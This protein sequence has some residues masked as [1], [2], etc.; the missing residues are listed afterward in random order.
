[1]ITRRSFVGV[2]SAVPFARLF[3]LSTKS[4]GRASLSASPGAGSEDFTKYVKIRIGTGGHGHTY[5]GA[6]VPFGMVQLSPD[7]Y[8]DGWDWCSGYHYSDSSI[9][10]FSHTHLSGTGASDMLDFLL[11]PGTGLTKLVPGARQNPGEGYRSR[12]SHEE[13]IAEPGY[14]SV[15]LRDY[16]IRAELSATERAGIHRYTF[17]KSDSSHFIL[18][19]V[20]AYGN[21][22]VVWAYLKVV[23]NDTIVGGRSMKGWAPDREIYFA[24]QFSK[25]FKKV[26]IV[27]DD[28]RMD[29]STRE[30][31]G[32]ALK[33]LLHFDTGDKEAI[34][35]KTGISGVSDEGARKNVAAEIPGWDFDKVRRSAHGAWNQQLSRIKIETTNQRHKRIFY[36]GLYHMLVAPT[37]FDDVDGQYRGM[38]NKIHQL[39][40][41]AHNYS[42]FSLWDTFRAAHPMYTLFQTDRV[43]DFVNCLIRMAQESP[44]G[45]PVW[46]LQG[47][48]TGT[49]TGYHSSSVYAEALVKGFKG[50]NFNQLYS[51]LRRRAMDDDYRGLGY[52]RKLGYI[53]CDKEEESVSKTMEY[54]Y[55]DW[56]VAHVAKALGHEDD[57]KLLIERSRNYKNLFDTGTTF[58]RPKLENG[59][60]AEP[61]DPTE[62]GHSKQWRD[63]TESDPWETTFSIQ[64]DPAGYIKLFGSREAFIEKLDTLFTTSSKLPADAPPDIAGMVG[65]YA[66]GNEVPSHGL[67]LSLRRRAGEDAGAGAKLAGDGVRRSAGRL[68]G[69]RRLRTDVGLVR[70]QCTRVLCGRSGER[71]LCFWHATGGSSRSRFGEWQETEDSSEADVRW[72]SLYSGGE[73]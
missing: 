15:V 37:L 3:G 57:Y 35:V 70:D 33:C 56:A 54:V 20:H 64:H 24:M 10:G 55:D 69:Q 32:N 9:M 29:F 28:K 62:M 39:E 63:Y 17:P 50:I 72:R 42:T 22:P 43:P 16:D 5:P 6:T 14:Y 30:V 73:L 21:T 11:M 12:F 27:S 19:L 46:P 61:F 52:Y 40:K 36:T 23:G 4:A 8:N 1:M 38:D 34:L 47:K 59:Q 26:E 44:E 7:T 25:P 13:E 45:V 67:S 60:W 51:P 65:Q 49:M 31:K 68:G 48:E 41:G 18:D 53:P 71:K 58:V 66:H 2:L